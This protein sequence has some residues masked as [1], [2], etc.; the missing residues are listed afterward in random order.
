[1]KRPF[2]ISFC[3]HLGLILS[4]LLVLPTPPPFKVAEPT[5]ITVDIST[6]SNKVQQQATTKDNTPDTKDNAP[7]PTK[8]TAD[9]PPAPKVADKVKLA[10]HEPQAVPVDPTPPEP[11]PEPPKP[12]AQPDTKALD[13]LVADEAAKQAA[14]DQKKLDD[15]KKADDKKKAEEKK[16]ADEKKKA[17]VKKK[18]DA[19]LAE[20]QLKLN[21]IAGESAAPAKATDKSGDPKHDEKNAAGD[22]A[23]ATATIVSALVS[24][25]KT[26]FTIPPAAR[27]ADV[28]VKIH[29]MLNPDGSLQGQPQAVTDSDNQV[30]QTTANAAISAIVECQNYDLP[31]DQ[32]DLW[33]DNVLDFNPTQLSG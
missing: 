18:L 8:V 17:E 21:K 5:P 16:K 13:Q 30:I 7:K 2:I 25:V 11:K 15:Q 12:T 31:A 19:A 24:K 23:A 27:D 4:A 29:F 26:C 33:K 32:Y 20:A 9:T 6:I 10:A 14:D 22:Q 28:S 3:I 1:M